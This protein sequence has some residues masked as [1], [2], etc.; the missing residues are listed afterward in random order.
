MK[1]LIEKLLSR[2]VIAYVIVGGLT[3]AVNY[4]VYYSGRLILDIDYRVINAIAWL[5]AVIFAYFA[6]RR[7]VFDSA[8]KGKA[9]W[10][11]FTG[12]AGSR[13][14]T[15]LLEEG[16][17][18]VTVEYLHLNDMWMKIAVS[19]VVVILNYFFSRMILKKKENQDE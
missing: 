6:N 2:E 8:E 3:T 7:Y 11:E 1:K 16:F 15:L 5:A 14:L 13:V 4:I 18:Q 12:F 9:N 19:V 17:L 10:K